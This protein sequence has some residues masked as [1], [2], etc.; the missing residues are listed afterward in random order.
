MRYLTFHIGMPHP[1]ATSLVCL[2]ERSL[3][4]LLPRYATYK[5][6][7][8]EVSYH[9]STGL[10]TGVHRKKKLSWLIL[11]FWIRLYEIKSLNDAYVKAKEILTFDF[12][13]K[14]FNPYDPHGICK[15]HSMKV[16]YP[17][18]HWT[19]ESHDEDPSNYCYNESKLHEMVIITIS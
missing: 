2:E 13:T 5:L 4:H 17:W 16:Y 3:L 15:N 14:D 18:I 9:L 10:S 19:F 11:P 8:Q 1:V 7:M 12:S 6:V